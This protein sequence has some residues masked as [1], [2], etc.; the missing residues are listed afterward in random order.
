[1]TSPRDARQEHHGEEPPR[2][3]YGQ[4][5]SM[6]MYALYG[7]HHDACMENLVTIR[8]QERRGPEESVLDQQWSPVLEY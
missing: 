3:I 5:F 1:M 2:S 8:A 6:D 7:E 4:V